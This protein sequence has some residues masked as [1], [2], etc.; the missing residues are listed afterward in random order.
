MPSPERRAWQR[1]PRWLAGARARRRRCWPRAGRSCSR[2]ASGGRARIATRRH[3]LGCLLAAAGRRGVWEAAPE[4]AALRSKG[5]AG[6][7]RRHHT[8]HTPTPTRPALHRSWRPGTAWPC[9][10]WQQRRACWRRSARR[11]SARSQ[12]RRGRL[13]ITCKRRSRWVGP[14][15]V[16]GVW[17]RGLLARW[18][19]SGGWLG[20]AATRP[21]GGLPWCCGRPRRRLSA[22]VSAAT[23]GCAP[24][25]SG[26]R[27]CAGAAVGRC[28]RAPAPRLHLGP[29]GGARL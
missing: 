22:W 21:A 14:G 6:G 11:R 13:A 28:R 17:V 23:C 4:D 29:L 9:R 12:W 7:R 25:S 3:A 18:H 26:G 15:F 10:R 1:Q 24:A 8:H 27:L 16:A 2:R 5:L 19:G 20:W